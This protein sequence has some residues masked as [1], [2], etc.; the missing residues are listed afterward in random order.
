MIRAAR[1]LPLSLAIHGTAVGGG[2]WLG[3]D[4]S[5][6][7]LF[8]DMRLI[9]SDVPPVRAKS[10]RA[11]SPAPPAAPAARRPAARS[12][13]A[14]APAREI[15]AAPPVAPAP[16][17]AAAPPVAAEPPTAAPSVT[18]VPSFAPT[19]SVTPEPS[20]ASVPPPV[21]APAADAQASPSGAQSFIAGET[22]AASDG[23]RGAASARS[24]VPS[25]RTGGEGEASATRG[26]T[27]AD[28]PLALAIP[29]DG[30]V[31]VYGPYLSALRRR[32]QEALEYP[33]A[34]RRRGL[35]GTVHLEV[36]LDAT[37]RVSEVLLARS[38]SHAVLDD[39]ALE[40][41]RRLPRV[42][43]P[44]EVRPRPLRVLMPVDFQLR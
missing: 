24:S 41:A 7:A 36:V 15:A 35:S 42:P 26:G 44:P 34:A 27:S 32:L 10:P 14:A 38:S 6:R 8:V 16:P 28:G 25:A 43:F 3:R 20:V 39:A 29:G 4:F 18:P 40:A 19:P 9:E 23:G 37:G 11:G 33:A 12:A 5:E 2:V 13:P 30:G 1:W 17:I 22:S 31:G 21:D